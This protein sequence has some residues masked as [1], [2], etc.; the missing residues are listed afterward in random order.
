MND[1]I[2]FEVRV[3]RQGRTYSLCVNYI[4][5]DPVVLKLLQ[6]QVSKK[7]SW[8]KT[9][10]PN[11][12]CLFYISMSCGPTK[13]N[14][15]IMDESTDEIREVLRVTG[16]AMIHSFYNRTYTWDLQDL[17]IFQKL[18]G[19]GQRMLCLLLQSAIRDGVLLPR[20]K[21]VLEASGRL[22]DKNMMGLVENYK[23]LGFQ[24]VYPEWLDACL[25]QHDVPMQA[26]AKDILQRCED[27][28]DTNLVS[29]HLVRQVKREA[30]DEIDT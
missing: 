21:I 29:R 7:Q 26:T 25:L 9:V 28:I 30:I 23:R 22:D 6:C 2:D 15:K 11:T 8:R 19:I 1:N 10:R 12:I 4:K 17:P 13:F 5:N 14:V 24:L 27:H 16:D 18:K 3:Y 20:S